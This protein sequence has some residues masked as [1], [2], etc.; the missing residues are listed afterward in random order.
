MPT[1]LLPHL[2]EP[3]DRYQ[4]ETEMLLVTHRTGVAFSEVRIRTIYE[5][6]NRSSHFRPIVDSA[7]IYGVLGRFVTRS[8][9]DS[10]ANRTAKLFRPA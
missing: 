9:F 2:M 7:K 1:C 8:L 4:F 6:G 3:A 10:L 5:D